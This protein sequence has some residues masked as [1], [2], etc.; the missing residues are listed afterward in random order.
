[1]LS[2]YVNVLCQVLSR[3]IY[4]NFDHSNYVFYHKYIAILYIHTDTCM[5]IC[6]YIHHFVYIVMYNTIDATCADQLH[7]MPHPADCLIAQE[8]ISKDLIP[9]HCVDHIIIFK[10]TIY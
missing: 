5:Y 8:R 1:M 4:L 2:S 6:I 3:N 10:Q 7:R 9:S